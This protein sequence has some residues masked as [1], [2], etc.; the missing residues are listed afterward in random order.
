MD[1]CDPLLLPRPVSRQGPRAA[2]GRSRRKG[3][4]TRSAERSRPPATGAALAHLPG[5]RPE[6]ANQ[7]PARVSIKRDRT[8]PH[9]PRSGPSADWTGPPEPLTRLAKPMTCANTGGPRENRTRNPRTR[10]P[11][12]WGRVG[13]G[14]RRSRRSERV[15]PSIDANQEGVVLGEDGRQKAAGDLLI[16]RWNDRG[17]G[18]RTG[19]S[20]AGQR[21]RRSNA[22]HGEPQ[23]RVPF[24][25]RFGSTWTSSLEPGSRVSS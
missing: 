13:P 1:V 15:R 25:F 17:G 21:Q 16:R 22:V 4:R 5:P 3:P 19:R 2:S 12:G 24:G 14:R 11:R 10:G 20:G 23:V 6:T 8:G 9:G 7:P 18:R